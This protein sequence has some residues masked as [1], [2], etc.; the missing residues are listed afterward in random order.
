[1][2]GVA[3]DVGEFA[4]EQRRIKRALAVLVLYEYYVLRSMRNNTQTEGGNEGLRVRQHVAPNNRRESMDPA[5]LLFLVVVE[6]V[7]CR[8]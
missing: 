4:L 3:N 8:K 7:A 5:G 6:R 2:N 1:M